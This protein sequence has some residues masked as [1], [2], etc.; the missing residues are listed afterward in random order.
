MGRKIIPLAWCDG[1]IT[2]KYEEVRCEE[3]ILDKI[4]NTALHDDLPSLVSLTDAELSLS[5]TIYPMSIN[6]NG[7]VF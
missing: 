4:G 7:F 6:D 2:Y 1:G 3:E 5:P